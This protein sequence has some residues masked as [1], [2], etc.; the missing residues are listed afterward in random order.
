[1]APRK[2]SDSHEPDVDP[3]PSAIDPAESRKVT[4]WGDLAQIDY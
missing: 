3:A 4:V 1:V 2:C